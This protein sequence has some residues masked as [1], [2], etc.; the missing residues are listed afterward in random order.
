MKRCSKCEMQ[1]VYRDFYRRKRGERAGQYYEKC[2]DCM[3]ARGRNYYHL[4]RN[5]QLHLAL[6]RRRKY[7]SK[8]KEYI[9]RLKDRPCQDCGKRY[10]SFVMDFDHR[11]GEKKFLDV[12]RMVLGGWALEKIK[13][14][15]QKCDIVCANCHRIR[16]YGK[17]ML[18]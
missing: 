11:L 13:I 8:A 14:E 1:K 2:K 9:A 15:I 16:T 12:T 7:L 3:K 6:I 10:P 5:R 17:Y 18:G 4:N